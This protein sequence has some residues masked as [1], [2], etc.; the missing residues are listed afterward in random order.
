M[1]T[2]VFLA[3][4]LGLFTILM[5]LAIWFNRRGMVAAVERLVQDS[6][7]LLIVELLGLAA[8]LANVI[9]HN[10]WHSLLAIVVTIVGWLILLRALALMFLSQETIEKIFEWVEWPKRSNLYALISFLIGLFLT[11]AG[12]AA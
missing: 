7:A 4:L 2:T 5:S 12:F 11:I 10:V 6:A 1:T 9:G 8:G 3:R